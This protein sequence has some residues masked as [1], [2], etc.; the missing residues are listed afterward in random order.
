MNNTLIQ[1]YTKKVAGIS[2]NILALD[3]LLLNHSHTIDVDTIKKDRF[4]LQ[5][6]RKVFLSVISDL[7]NEEDV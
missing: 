4:N 6:Q 2:T 7:N 1:R 5:I 3:K